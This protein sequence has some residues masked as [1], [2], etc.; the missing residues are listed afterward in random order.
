MSTKTALVLGA[1]GGIGG[2]VTRS[3]LRHGWQVRALTRNPAQPID[4]D[5]KGVVWIGGDAMRAADV[6]AAAQGAE[7]LFHGANPPGY[8]NWRGLAIPMLRHAIDAAKASGARLIY[9][10]SVYPY[11]R[12]AWPLVS[13]DGAAASPQPQGRHSRRDGGDAARRTRQRPP[14]PHRARRRFLWS[15]C[16]EFLGRIG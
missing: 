15:P 4:S 2:E 1:T 12:D 3:L 10:G 16:A 5:L 6:I 8:R 9:P 7:I 11:G 13:E 14:F